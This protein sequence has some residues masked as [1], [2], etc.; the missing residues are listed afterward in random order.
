MLGQI[1]QVFRD[2]KWVIAIALLLCGILLVPNQV[3]ELYRI[4]AIEGKFVALFMFGSVAVISLAI[5]LGAIQI[6]AQTQS[7]GD[8]TDLYAARLNRYLPVVLGTLPLLCAAIALFKSR[9]SLEKVSEEARQVGSVLRVQYDT[10]VVVKNTLLIY[11]LIF[12]AMACIIA[13]IMGLLNSR[14][15][16]V[17]IKTNRVY[18]AR[19]RFLVA[20]AII[21]VLLAILFVRYPVGFA[22]ALGSFGVL[23]LFT[24]C[25][26]AVCVHLS[27]ITI[28]DR[29][30]YIPL[31]LICVLL[32]S[33]FD[34][35]DNHGVRT[36]SVKSAADGEASMPKRVNAA[37]AFEAWL[38]QRGLPI[39]GPYN[40]N[41]YPVFIVTAQGGGIYAA[42]NAAIFLARM[43]D[44][45]PT[46]HHHLFAISGVSGGSIGASTFAAALDA[47]GKA[48]PQPGDISPDP[49]PR[50]RR[51]LSNAHADNLDIIGNTEANVD[52][53]LSSDF[54]SPLL[55]STLFPDFMQSLIPRPVGSL[56][57][58]RALEFTLESAAGQ[59]YARKQSPVG[60]S[61]SKT[62]LTSGKTPNLL[63]ESFQAHWSPSGAIPALLLNATDSG[64]GKRIVMSPFDLDKAK[65]ETSDICILTPA[66][67]A[68]DFALS[69]AAFI[70]ARFPWVTPAATTQLLDPNPCIADKL[71]KKI[72][73]VD[74]GY[75][76]NSGVETALDLVTEMKKAVREKVGDPNADPFPI[77]LISLSS[78]DFPSKR[79]YSMNELM[80]PIR[81]LLNGREARAAI[82]LN[83]ARTESQIVKVSG[84]PELPRFNRT[85][86]RS[87]FYDLPLGWA[88][89]DKT[90]DII[91]LDSGRFWDCQPS[92]SFAQTN[93]NLSNADCVQLQ[94]YHLLNG[95]AT[96][97]LAGLEQANKIA[98]RMADLAKAEGDP[99]KR[100]R[101][102]D[103]LICYEKK[104]QEEKFKEWERVKGATLTPY[105]KSYLSHNQAEHVR[106]L[107]REWDRL[108]VVKIPEKISPDAVKNPAIL[109]YVLGSLSYDSNDF[110][111]LTENVT[112]KS[113][114]QIEGSSWWRLIQRI[115]KV[116]KDANSSAQDVDTNSL[117]N[118]PEDFAELV[119][120][121]EKNTF[122]NNIRSGGVYDSKLKEGWKYRP[123]GVYQ[124]VGRE[125]YEAEGRRLKLL[126]DKLD[127]K[128]LL[129]E[130][131]ALWD[132]RI[133]AKVAFAH[134]LQWS[135]PSV[136]QGTTN[137]RAKKRKEAGL[138][139]KTLFSVVTE[140][141]GGFELARR[142]QSDMGDGTKQDE[143]SVAARSELFK[144]CIQEAQ[145]K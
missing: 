21:T 67:R 103:L 81:A 144:T 93:A 40:K 112:F 140:H 28:R 95:S 13:V 143:A 30:P 61:D 66:K 46:F 55:A 56:D 104:W 44:L 78:G 16:A 80:E 3:I 122:G 14:I 23:A 96:S 89:S 132:K 35:N 121:W 22:S 119:W 15:L 53:A 63:A 10:L 138:E 142:N 17:S 108:N 133:S 24:V 100:T 42:Y 34:L 86:L 26:T 111:R 68:N 71:V 135:S 134:F 91:A 8:I 118:K 110:R 25:L 124:I 79:D 98:A 130:P 52:L 125:Q 145:V 101:H 136:A 105:K 139:N 97:A 115:N 94:I 27:L 126:N 4:A 82:A 20:T 47:A 128:L 127:D 64:S 1:Y 88:M 5:W 7:S 43:Q 48:G 37:A 77:Y 2:S 117:I 62:V 32:I 54:L 41:P 83:R 113:T 123:R 116:R 19:R 87:Y 39:G 9:P 85:N 45:C 60:S 65:S 12:L 57:R 69:T 6:A 141:P 84:Q 120:G 92:T 99:P 49:C 131:D 38:N 74:G 36:L 107:L 106:E 29:I 50:M 33:L 31:I 51:F 102:E 11:G 70:S 129:D 109:A 76:D 18:F 58:A 90:R 59:M 137:D 75:I 72:R 73:L 114:N